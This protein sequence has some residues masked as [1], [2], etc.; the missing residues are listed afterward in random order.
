MNPI[1]VKIALAFA[2]LIL[3][4]YLVLII[5]GDRGLMDLRGMR[6]QLNSLKLENKTLE[7]QNIEM[8]RKI[9]RLKEDPAYTESIARQELRMIGKDELVFEFKTETPHEED[10]QKE[11]KRK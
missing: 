5:T 2:V 9:K 8:Y 1:H 4:S 6:H 10:Q 7:Q 11:Q 3:L